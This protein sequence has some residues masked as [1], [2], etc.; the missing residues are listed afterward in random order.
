MKKTRKTRQFLVSQASIDDSVKNKTLMKE[1]MASA[2]F[3]QLPDRAAR[4]ILETYYAVHEL[5][6]EE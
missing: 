6:D 4:L 2:E 3:K 5:A 1:A